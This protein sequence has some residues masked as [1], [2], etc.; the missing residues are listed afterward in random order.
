MGK[1]FSGKHVC[2]F[3]GLSH[4]PIVHFLASRFFTKFSFRIWETMYGVACMRPKKF[5]K[6]P[7]ARRIF[8]KVFRRSHFWTSNSC[9]FSQEFFESCA[10]SFRNITKLIYVIVMYLWEHNGHMFLR[11]G[12]SHFLAPKKTW[13]KAPTLHVVV[14]FVINNN[15]NK[16]IT[17]R[18]ILRGSFGMWNFHMI[19]NVISACD[20]II[21]LLDDNKND[22]KW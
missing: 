18:R 10:K 22:N 14:F 20:A 15:D 6:L 3:G 12:K 19:L 17:I 21:I 2:P 5:R 8:P 1:P 9:P 13:K 16:M 7:S 11:E 4:Y